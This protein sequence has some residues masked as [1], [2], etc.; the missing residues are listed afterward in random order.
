MAPLRPHSLVLVTGIAGYL[1][2]NVGYRALRGGLRVRG[3]VNDVAS[4]RR[5]QEIYER[6]GIK[7]EVLDNDLE[8]TIVED[9]TS[10][11]QWLPSLRGV[12]GVA[13]VLFLLD[14]IRKS[15]ALDKAVLVTLSLLRAAHKVPGIQR[16]ILTSSLASIACAGT[17]QDK[18]L[19]VDD[20]N[21]GLV[22]AIEVGDPS[23]LPNDTTARPF[24]M[25]CAARTRAERLAWRFMQMEKPNF[26]LV[27]LLRGSLLGPMLMLDRDG[28]PPSTTKWIA[29]VLKGNGSICRV[30]PRGWFVDV[31]D[32]A[33]LHVIAFTNSRLGGRRLIAAA[34]PFGW[35]AIFDILRQHF[36]LLNIPLDF[37]GGS[38][39][40]QKFDNHVA[41]ELLGKWISLEQSIV[42]LAHRLGYVNTGH[43]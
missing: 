35:N 17:Y 22:G 31:R 40:P 30:V 42:E 29:E 41:T 21:D 37:E 13:H 1:G 8:F 24:L 23:G 5:V 36:P 38:P 32:C 39:D 43:R 25:Y 4:A 15:D 2:C 9:F 3:T 33:Q 6:E 16:I 14:D 26:D 19:T 10:E 34:A 28:Q 20:W 12:H 11:E 27:T 7:A 18:L